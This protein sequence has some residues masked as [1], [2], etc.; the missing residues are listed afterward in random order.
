MS[1]DKI[2]ADISLAAFPML[3]HALDAAEQGWYVFPCW[4]RDYYTDPETGEPKGA[5]SPRIGNGHLRATRDPDQI[6]QWWGAWY[7]NAMI[8]AAVPDP[9]IVIDIDPRNGGSLR[10]LWE[11]VGPLPT[12]LTAWSGR[13]DGGHHLYFQRPE[14]DLTGARLPD[15][16]DLKVGGKGYVILPPSIH[17]VTGLPYEWEVH[18]I[19][20]APGSLR[21][22]LRAP[23]RTCH[24]CGH[25]PHGTE[26]CQGT[27]P[28]ATQPCECRPSGGARS[29]AGLIRTVRESKPGNRNKPLY[30]A[31]RRARDLGILDKIEG[32]LLAAS[33]ASGHDAHTAQRT[34]ESAR[35][36]AA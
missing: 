27:K 23:V 18:P 17:P 3:P 10:S 22:L 8:S 31:A 7:P 30:V 20:A 12:T 14:G 26:Q 13:N 9:L 19:A 36:A 35:R 24:R 5:K 11:R 16:I 21:A 32:D 6:R 29:G 1:N 33:I 2:N 15:G 4:E 28:Y 25:A 34:I